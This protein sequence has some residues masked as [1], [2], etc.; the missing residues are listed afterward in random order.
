MCADLLRYSYFNDFVRSKEEAFIKNATGVCPLT[1]PHYFPSHC[2]KRT[3]IARK[4]VEVSQRYEFAYHS[5]SLMTHSGDLLITS[6]ILV[7]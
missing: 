2:G 1:G 7:C 5:Y 6:E 4:L 3:S